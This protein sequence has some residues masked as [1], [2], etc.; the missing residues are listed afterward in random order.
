MKTG[1]TR[2]KKPSPL[3]TTVIEVICMILTA[4]YFAFIIIY[5]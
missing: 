1:A 2:N 4:F 3:P 5:M